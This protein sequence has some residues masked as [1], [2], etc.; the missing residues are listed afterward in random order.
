MESS[1]SSGI[2]EAAAP[3]LPPYGAVGGAA[4]IGLFAPFGN[5]GGGGTLPFCP[6]L[7]GGGGGG[8]LFIDGGG[9]GGGGA[10][11]PPAFPGGA[12][13]AGGPPIGGAGGPGGAGGKLKAAGC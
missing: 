12:G 11:P 8:S 6:F 2:D 7:G 10:P 3:V 4:I 13:G 9:G 5:A 1:G